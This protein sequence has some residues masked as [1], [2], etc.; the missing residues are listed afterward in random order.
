MMRKQRNSLYI[1]FVIWA[2]SIKC[3]WHIFA[4]WEILWILEKYHDTVVDYQWYDCGAQ[5][6]RLNKTVILSTQSISF[7]WEIRKKY[8]GY[9]L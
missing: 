3:E 2:S 9:A 7:G 1:L 6:N 5:K 4:L 8:I